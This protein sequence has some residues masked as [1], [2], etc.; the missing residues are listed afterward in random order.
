MLDRS[1]WIRSQAA[2]RQWTK[3]DVDE[4]GTLEEEEVLV[5]A[6]WVWCSVNPGMKISGAARREQ[7]ELI[8][9]ESDADRNGIMSWTEP[10]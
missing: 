7:A 2:K 3:L 5:L 9:Q 6:E 8:W 10:I 1:M 4:S